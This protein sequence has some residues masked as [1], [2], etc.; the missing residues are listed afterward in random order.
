MWQ[1]ERTETTLR[2]D[3]KKYFEEGVKGK[4]S[5]QSAEEKPA[6]KLE[7]PGI[8]LE[9]PAWVGDDARCPTP[10]PQPSAPTRACYVTPTK[11]AT[12]PS[13]FRFVA[14]DLRARKT[15]QRPGRFR[16]PESRESF[17]R[18]PLAPPG[19][20][21]CSPLARRAPRPRRFARPLACAVPEPPAN[22]PRHVSGARRPPKRATSGTIPCP[23][24]AGR[25]HP[26]RRGLTSP[27]RTTW[28]AYAERGR[29]SR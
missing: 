8:L 14:P 28:G 23:P 29:F 22:A 7:F 15:H 6:K 2:A 17:A 27:P 26:S 13:S 4:Q 21:T 16:R 5:R 25:R 1:I 10:L 20:V 18:F 11:D 24:P 3:F 19:R 12:V 9:G